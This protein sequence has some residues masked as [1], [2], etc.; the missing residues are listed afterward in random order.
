MTLKVL[1]VDVDGTLVGPGGDLFA[2]PDHEPSLAAAEAIVAARGA[3]LELVPLSGRHQQS[4][5]ELARVIGADSWIG[6]LGALRSYQRGR[7]LVLDQGDYPGEGAAVDELRRAG[8]S[9]VDLHRGQLEGHA[10]WNEHRLASYM[11]R[12]DV[13]LADLHAWL[14]GHD[15][16]WADCIDNGVI[17]RS[18]EGL[19]GLDRVRVF[20]L[21]PKGVSKQAAVAAD[22]DRRGLEPAECAVIGD[23]AADLACAPEVGRAFLVANALDKDPGLAAVVD[24]TPNA[25][26]TDHAYGA[27]F[28]DVVAALTS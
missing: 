24:T 27:G 26:V 22:R 23:S 3:G 6:E 12:G 7:E 21:V 10:P 9:L 16:G 15:Y 20:H 11:I 8:A 19:P 25:E 13:P 5:S 28:A 1:Y 4:M 17:P 18:Y 14:D 2:G